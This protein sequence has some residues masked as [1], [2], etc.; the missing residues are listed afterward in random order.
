MA[1]R[2]DVILG[3]GASVGAG[4]VVINASLGAVARRM[5]HGELLHPLGPIGAAVDGL[6]Q[7]SNL[8][9][10][11]GTVSPVQTEGPYYTPNSPQRRDIRDFGI[12]AETLVVRGRVLDTQCQP[13]A[14]AILDFWQTGHDGVYD[15]HGYRYRGYQYTDSFGRFELVTVPPQPYGARNRFGG[16][17]TAHIHVKVQA[18]GT[19]LLTTQLYLPDARE[20]NEI[21]SLYDPSLAIEYVQGDGSARH[22]VFDFVLANA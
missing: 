14:G 10:T 21:D 9:C 4:F 11:A 1:K 5:Q 18:Q 17:R 15:Q 3:I 6:P 12:D 22:A 2:R 8:R 7:S 13:L 16:F 20:N 19:P